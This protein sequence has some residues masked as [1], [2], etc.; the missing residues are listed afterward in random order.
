MSNYNKIND[1]QRKKKFIDQI[2]L[3]NWMYG[4]QSV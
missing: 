1:N 3:M 2:L 4:G